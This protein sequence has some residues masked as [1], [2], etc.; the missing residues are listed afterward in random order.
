ML[1]GLDRR[2]GEMRLLVVPSASWPGPEREVVVAEPRDLPS[3][4]LSVAS[5]L[6]GVAEVTELLSFDEDFEE[7]VAVEAVDALAGAGAPKVQPAVVMAA[8]VPS[9]VR[10]ASGTKKAPTSEAQHHTRCAEMDVEDVAAWARG[11]SA[12]GGAA[13]SAVAEALRE[14]EVDGATLLAYGKSMVEFELL[15][16][17]LR[18]KAGKATKLFA[19]VQALIGGEEAP[20]AEGI[21]QPKPRGAQPPTPA[22]A[23]LNP[24]GTSALAAELV[25]LKLGSLSQRATAAGVDGEALLEAQDADDAKAALIA[26]ILARSAP[27]PD[28]L[29]GLRA[30]LSELRPGTLGKRAR[31]AGASEEQV[32]V[33]QD[34]DEPKES[35]IALILE[36]SSKVGLVKSRPHFKPGGSSIEA[37]SLPGDKHDGFDSDLI[38]M[39]GPHVMLSYQWDIQDAVV[40]V[41]QILTR[42]KIKTWMDIDGG[43]EVDLYD[44]MAEGVSNA[45]CVVCFMTQQYEDSQNCKMELKF[46]KDKN[47]PIIPVMYQGGEWRAGG[48]LGLITSG[49]LWV[50][51]NDT[52][53]F[54]QSVELL[55]D[56]IHKTSGGA[57]GLGDAPASGAVLPVS[58]TPVETVATVLA[59]ESPPPL[60]GS[61]AG[62]LPEL[63]S[64]PADCPH[65]SENTR[66]ASE[67]H[68]LKELLLT[69]GGEAKSLE[70][71]SQKSL[72]K[73]S[74]VG[75]HGMGG[76][77]KTVMAAWI[78]RDL[79]IRTHFDL[80]LWITCSQTPNIPKLLALAYLQATG[81]EVG[82]GKAAEEIKQMVKNAIQGKRTLLI[83][84]DVWEAAQEVALNC[85]DVTDSTASRVLVTT[86]I[87]GLLPAGSAEHVSIGLPSKE[88]ALELLCRSAG[89]A[90]S[91][92][93]APP[94]EAAEVVELCGRLPLALDIAGR[95]VTDMG[96]GAD[97]WAGVPA[98]LKEEMAAASGEETSLEYRIISTSMNAIPAR[99]LQGCRDIFAVLATV[100][101]DTHV[102]PRAFQIMLSAVSAQDGMVP[103]LQLR[104][105]MQLLINR[106]LVLNNW[107]RP[108]LHDIVRDWAISQ[109]SADELMML[110]RKVVSAL[111]E[112]RPESKLPEMRGTF[113]WQG[114]DEVGIYVR[115]EIKGHIEGALPPASSGAALPACVD[116]WLSQAAVA[117][118]NPSAAHMDDHLIS[119]LVTVL[120]REHLTSIVLRSLEGS[121]V[122]SMVLA[123]TATHGT[124][125][126][127]F[128]Q[129]GPASFMM[130][131]FYHVV[132]DFMRLTVALASE[133]DADRWATC[134]TRV[135][136]E[137]LL[138]RDLVM[139]ASMEEFCKQ[140]APH[141]L[142]LIDLELMPR[143]QAKVDN[144]MLAG[145]GSTGDR[146]FHHFSASVLPGY[147]NKSA[148]DFTLSDELLL[149]AWFERASDVIN[150]PAAG[151]LAAGGELA[152]TVPVGNWCHAAMFAQAA[153]NRLPD[154]DW[155]IFGDGMSA[156]ER[157]LGSLDLDT[158]PVGEVATL[159]GLLQ[160]QSGVGWACLF[161]GELD[162]W[163]AKHEW[164]TKL[165]ELTLELGADWPQ[166][167]PW[168][169]AW[170]S[171]LWA[172]LALTPTFR[173]MAAKLF[174]KAHPA[175]SL[176]TIPALNDEV[177]P[178]FG[179]VRDTRGGREVPDDDPTAVGDHALSGQVHEWLSMASFVLLFGSDCEGGA[180]FIASLPTPD[181]MEAE[182]LVEKHY[183][184]VRVGCM[185][186]LCEA[187]SP[188]PFLS[189]S[190]RMLS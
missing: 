67:M 180:E 142:E 108:Q 6:G 145:K 58:A 10:F 33:A 47:V 59:T 173:P 56:Q 181:E 63:A 113:A 172:E 164:T 9:S 27:A 185:G 160:F 166:R 176:S 156:V 20:I 147:T 152:R 24:S 155:S 161:R 35:L 21:P 69:S 23:R 93:Q 45:A 70:V 134:C 72:Q 150:N 91:S 7:W 82:Q 189:I 83:L 62:S 100:A 105:W 128:D 112:A 101:E 110:Q 146:E 13:Q 1:G 29:E 135:E 64:L 117:Y 130:E 49:A 32:L 167:A 127:Y 28:P 76:V 88:E 97:D 96:L 115:N 133:H 54:E 31:E 79:D 77:G 148:T 99:D 171:L 43:M 8:P 2:V 169:A 90:L 157:V 42:K 4:L 151:G 66:V 149:S 34:T 131:D 73:S 85:V 16:Q 84:D 183:Y 80:I 141:L 163:T 144:M 111:R 11:L 39:L 61:N 78:A 92:T 55:S 36:V 170:G 186:N 53:P 74:K 122:D 19:A 125:K 190:T 86:R 44:S 114:Q 57:L 178:T 119:A 162:V 75:A 48:W 136:F 123:R 38:A 12:F 68:S 118:G 158:L 107:E 46:A 104:K 95:L 52:M 109:H 3:L 103:A 179:T 143:I 120:G 138:T 89:V 116:V 137:A 18:L 121:T 126:V 41:R 65:L 50:P 14:E 177:L 159:I 51:M 129:F 81:S 188:A 153:L 26:L 30:E 17:I 165:A 5:A 102:P 124:M 154:W 94:R 22:A 15:R 132:P 25:G 37:A 139:A 106:S 40:K 98:M 140:S 87:K 168:D 71:S 175:V 60:K 187:H 182:V 174:T 184:H